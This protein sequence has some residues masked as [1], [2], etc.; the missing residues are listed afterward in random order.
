MPIYEFRCHA[1]GKKFEL[2]LG[3]NDDPTQESCP[4]CGAKKYSKLVSNFRRLR[5]EDDKID[6]IADEL[7][8][9][10]QPESASQMRNYIKEMGRATD[11]D[12]SE[13]LEEMFESDLENDTPGDL[14]E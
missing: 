12:M 10:D 2:L 14:A 6:H 4:H 8:G 1:C 11:D 3:I 7:E 13:E 9:M 5:S